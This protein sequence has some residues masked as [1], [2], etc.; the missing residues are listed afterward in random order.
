MQLQKSFLIQLVS[1]TAI[2]EI[3]AIVWV[4]FMPDRW[5]TPLLWYLPLFFMSITYLIHKSFVGALKLNP[6]QFVTRYMLITTIK[7]LSFL[8]ILFTYALLVK[9]DALAFLLS[10]FVLYLIYSAFEA[11]AVIRLNNEFTKK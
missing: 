10:F 7:L 9:E 4:F 6:T 2:L 11:V 5:V 1:L 8:A 3:V